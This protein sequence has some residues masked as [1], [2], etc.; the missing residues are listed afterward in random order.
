MSWWTD[1]ILTTLIMEDVGPEDGPQSFPAV[2]FVNDW[3]RVNGSHELY[4][5]EY[6]LGVHRIDFVF[7]SQFKD[8]ITR[9]D[10]IRFASRNGQAGNAM[11][12]FLLSYLTIVLI[13][14]YAICKAEIL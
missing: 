8:V 11:T 2:E 1:V 3:L 4:H 14:D 10:E 13:V 7:M 6:P 12:I 5:P 9:H